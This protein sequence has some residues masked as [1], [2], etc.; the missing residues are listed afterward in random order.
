M[1]LIIY[2]L[3]WLG[4]L[5]SFPRKSVLG[6]KNL[7]VLVKSLL[8]TL[9]LYGL[10]LEEGYIP[11]IKLLLLTFLRRQNCV[12][13]GLGE[14]HVNHLFVCCSFSKSIWYNLWNKC[15]IPWLVGTRRGLFGGWPPVLKANILSPS[16]SK[17]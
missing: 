2:G 6:V 15:N 8:A 4:T 11:K 3:K 9:L 5:F 12:L 13:R 17:L 7:C 14:E 1:S 16:W 10:Q